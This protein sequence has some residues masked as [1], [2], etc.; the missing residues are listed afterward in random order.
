MPI[1]EYGLVRKFWENT[2]EYT[3]ENFLSPTPFLSSI[4]DQVY[5][6]RKDLY[7]NTFIGL[8]S[9]W[10]K[11]SL[12]IDYTNFSKVNSLN[13]KFYTTY[14]SPCDYG[15]KIIAI[16]EGMDDV[17]RIVSIEK[18]S[19]KEEI[20]F[21]PGMLNTDRITCANGK[22]VWDE[23]LPDIRWTNRDYSAIRLF[24]IKTGK[25]SY[26]TKHSKYYAPAIAPSKNLIAVVSTDNV[27]N[28]A[29]ILLNADNGSIIQKFPI[30]ENAAVQYPSWDDSSK[31]LVMTL[32][33][34]QGKGLVTLNTQTGKWDVL[35]KPATN[36]M[37]QPR[38]AN[39]FII[40]L[41]DYSGID[42]VYAFNL[43]NNKIFQ[44]TSSK[45][46]ANSPIFNSKHDTLI[47][48]NYTSQGY[49]VVFS[50][51]DKKNWIPLDS[52]KNISLNFPEQLAAQEP[53][54]FNP[55][56]VKYIHYDSRPYYRFSHLINVHSWTP[57]YFYQNPLSTIDYKLMPGY[58][59][60]SQDLHS[61]LMATAGQGYYNRRLYSDANI[62]YKEFFP[63]LQFS[64]IH[65]DKIGWIDK[66]SDS[67]SGKSLQITGSVSLPFNFSQGNEVTSFIPVLTLNRTNAYFT[68]YDSSSL[69]QWV[70]MM[71]YSAK[72]LTYKSM[73]FKDILP[74]IGISL[75]ALYN[76]VPGEENFFSQ[77]FASRVN[78]YL[79]GIIHHQTIKLSYGFENQNQKQYFEVNQL[80]PPRGYFWDGN[81][82]KINTYS[83]DYVMPLVYPDKAIFDVFYLKR[84]YSSFYFENSV[85]KV[86][87]NFDNQY[88]N[89]YFTS[90]GIELYFD[91]N[92]FFFPIDGYPFFNNFGI[93]ESYIPGTHSFYFELMTNV[94][95][96]NF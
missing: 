73:S 36:D 45:F 3:G 29:I 16:K 70:N 32:L 77:Q 84:I 94:N 71:E 21:T 34:E 79:P 11:K 28:N 60:A 4:K 93:R 78:F 13:K 42:N 58:M 55:A 85:Y 68:G 15:D 24:D 59:I 47:Y 90:F 26:L 2:L 75:N 65:G 95:L 31:F 35:I 9:L 40:F 56:E 83:I 33:N 25:A 23:Y 62:T 19:G 61:T 72:F 66:S 10:R 63:V 1:T 82:Q 18:S 22:I 48:T 17:P 41:G 8:D 12:E 5:M 43:N 89:K 96:L 86:F 76:N 50:K 7:R 57:F 87:N 74:R 20:L 51:I 81:A 69:Y 52:V 53:E 37:S 30:P 39:N 49:D 14:H 92:L 67:F 54:K 27:G 88:Y 64:V 80:L 6:N 38:F 91:Y 46:G 44:I